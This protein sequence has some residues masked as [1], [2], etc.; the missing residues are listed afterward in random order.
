MT[1]IGR[2]GADPEITTTSTGGEIIKYVVATSYG[3]K[4][5][6]QTSWFR[7]ASFAEKQS[8][9][10]EKVMGLSKGYVP[11]SARLSGNLEN[12]QGCLRLTGRA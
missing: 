3:P 5:N 8:P 10:R 12:Q 1:L 6:R 4:E 9:L 2:I 7:V 11:H